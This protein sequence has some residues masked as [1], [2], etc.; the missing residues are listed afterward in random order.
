MLTF[1]ISAGLFL[2]VTLLY[3]RGKAFRKKGQRDPKARWWYWGIGVFS[4]AGLLFVLAMLL[5]KI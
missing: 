3:V 2:M 4:G 5:H 1:L